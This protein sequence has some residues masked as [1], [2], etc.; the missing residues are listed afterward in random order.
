M[1]TQPAPAPKDFQQQQLQEQQTGMEEKLSAGMMA[2]FSPLSSQ[3]L[4]LCS[5]AAKQ[6]YCRFTLEPDLL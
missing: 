6:S 3:S 5:K 1:R 4:P 2:D